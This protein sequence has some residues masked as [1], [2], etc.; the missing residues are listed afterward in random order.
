MEA[1]ILI[2][3]DDINVIQ[4]IAIHLKDLGYKDI[5]T[6]VSKEQ[7]LKAIGMTYP[8][9]AIL[10]IREPND[11]EAGINIAR[12]L[13]AIKP[14][15]IIYMTAY[16]EDKLLTYDTLP[17]AFIEKPNYVDV[18][19]AIDIAVRN[20]YVIKEK[21]N[22]AF[23]DDNSVFA[24]EEFIFILKNGVYFKVNKKDILFVHAD[25]GCI[26]IN[27]LDN[28]YPISSTIKRF[29]EQIRDPL[30]LLVHR[31]YYINT[32]HIDSFERGQISVGDTKIPMSK[33]GYDELLKRIR[34]LRAK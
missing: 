18:F 27:S 32:R 23:A 31:S 21:S 34:R 4:E 1:K 11:P 8:D 24:L 30:F 13:N 2:F 10:D 22:V 5:V 19:H 28:I 20:F 7:A 9:I 17:N 29:A 3:E 25:K 6:A 16:P 15:P 14:I 33:S 12:R 26:V